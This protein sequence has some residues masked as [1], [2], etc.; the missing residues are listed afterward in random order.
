MTTLKKCVQAASGGKAPEEINVTKSARVPSSALVGRAEL[1]AGISVFR[2]VLT[3]AF[4]FSAFVSLLQFSAPIY[5]LQVYDRVLASGSVET[6][7]ALSILLAGI[8]LV[9]GLL[10]HA[11]GRIVARVG[12]RFQGALEGRVLD[13]A[14]RRLALVPQDTSAL[15]AGRDLDTVARFWASPALLALFDL[16]W[17]PAFFLAL[18]VFHPWLGYL[19]LAGA[20]IL[21]LANWANQRATDASLQTAVLAGLA[22]DRL[23]AALT[24]DSELIRAMGMGDAASQRWKAHRA[25]ARD[26]GLAA[27]DATGR[28]SVAIRTLRLFLQSA[29]LGLAAF[30]VLQGELTAG[31]MVA[32]S[33]LTGRALHPLEQVVAHWPSLSKA[34]QARLRLSGLLEMILPEIPRTAL[35]RPA[36][37]LEVQGLTV[38]PPGAASPSLRGVSFSLSPGQVMGVIG[39][40]GSGKS[41]LARALVGVW[42][43]A[44]G[45]VRLDGATLDRFDPARLGGWIGYLP[46]RVSLFDGTV[47]ENIARLQTG[48]DPHDVI[49]AARAAAAH[50][51]ILRLPEGYDTRLFAGGNRLSGGQIQRIGLARA[52]YGDPV[53]VVLDEPN[54]N[55]DTEGSEALN[56]ALRAARS[57]GAAV[58]IMAHRP[59]ALQECDLLLVL[60]EGAVAACGPRDQVLREAVKNAGELAQVIGRAGTA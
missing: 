43:P 25:V 21:C 46:Q 54:A 8:F 36:A 34:R 53:L 57:I 55:L 24:S 39:P 28:W 20:L 13:A 15:A 26:A 6:L 16:P 56:Q 52:I 18:F 38:I 50:E 30:L 41:T 29:M 45:Q 12:A 27:A 9:M 48:A 58:L 60:K 10:D 3:V 44:M 22:A 32:A 7:V 2:R 5:M 31:A 51:M 11:R 19:A 23:S 17:I 37:R 59:A 1:A 35:P 47:A 42:R 33:I 4:V 49:A 40:S 14:L